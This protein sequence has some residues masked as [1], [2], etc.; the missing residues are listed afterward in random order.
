MTVA[1]SPVRPTKLAIDYTHN[2]VLWIDAG[3]NTINEADLD[4]TN[5]RV[6]NRGGKTVINIT[7]P[8]I[9]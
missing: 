7:C 4:G 3:L 5:H 2:K 6:I 1:A 8:F 9:K